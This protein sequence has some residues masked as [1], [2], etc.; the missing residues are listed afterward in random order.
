MTSNTPYLL[1]IDQGTT[2][3]RTIAFDL[4]GHVLAQEQVEL[5]Q[6]YPQAG[7]VEHD[8]EEIWQ[9]TITT[10]RAVIEQCAGKGHPAA[11]GI[12]NQR[13]TTVLWER[14]TGKPVHRAIVWQD[15]RTDAWCQ[16]LKGEGHED[17]VNE[18]TGLLIDPYFS[19]T[20]IHWLLDQNPELQQRAERGELAFGTIESYLLWHLTGG[21]HASDATN[22]SRTLLLNIHTRQWDDDLLELFQVPRRLL[23]EVMPNAGELGIT[24]Q[25]IFGIEIPIT[26]MAGDQQ[27]AAIGQAC[28][29]PGM[30]KST[31]G[32][33]CFLLQNIGSQ[34]LRSRN[35]LLT[36]IAYDIGGSVNY[37]LE[38]SIYMA[39][40]AMNWVRDQM[41]L[42]QHASESAELAASI[43][44]TQGV[45]F[46][47]AMTG[48][49]AP[50]WRSEARGLICGLTLGAGRAEIV[51]ATLEAVAYQTA[52]L[53]D[54]IKQD[55]AA[56][57]P[58]IRV[59]G[60][61]ANNDWLAQFLADVLNVPV[62]RP[63]VTETTALG[64]AYLAALGAG[65]I[66]SLDDLSDQWQCEKRFEP[67][68]RA[69]RRTQ[70]LEGWRQAV[71]R[72]I[73]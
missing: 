25:D 18:K 2:S 68:M 43:E 33:G 30:V 36:T 55:G 52:D 26:G 67:A 47:P 53:I 48:L 14:A 39:G 45:Y 24:H 21:Q 13:E 71:R 4:R 62:E 6:Y 59:D 37:A 41:G 11:L 56:K 23:P 17:W 12:T 35:R 32:T 66:S 5:S 31:Y 27:A 44:D 49:G 1:A 73:G 28:I 19:A 7:W 46:V 58:I 34:A 61:M 63:P 65:M 29:H 72:T 57:P 3:T 20:K 10:C 50:H 60:G 16:K 54:A 70:L 69:S 22:A 42:I 40:A 64:A 15:R 9:A 51:R 8:A 38:G